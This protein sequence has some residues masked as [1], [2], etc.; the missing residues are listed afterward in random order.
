MENFDFARKVFV[1]LIS[2][3][4]SLICGFYDW[5]WGHSTASNQLQL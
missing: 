3:L 2:M 1:F 5:I 4:S